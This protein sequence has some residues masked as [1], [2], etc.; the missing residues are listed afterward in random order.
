MPWPKGKPMPP[1]MKAK[2]VATLKANAKT[3]KTTYYIGGEECWKCPTCGLT[4]NAAGFYKDK[5]T[6][7]GLTSQCK[8]CH[9]EGNIRTRD[10]SKACDTNRRYMR[11]ARERDPEKFRARERIAA[12]K[13]PWTI[14]REA[15]YQLNLAIRRRE[16]QKPILCQRCEKARK[17]T[18]H[19]DDYT[20]PLDVRWLCYECH[21][22]EH[23]HN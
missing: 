2:R 17:L 19:H 10:A 15:R 1:N 3:V 9:T 6:S 12:R 16:V 20:K 21:G 23:R 14:Q 7:N 4:L 18:A 13:R 8:R 5:R 11:A 22:L